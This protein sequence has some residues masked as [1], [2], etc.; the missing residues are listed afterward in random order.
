MRVQIKAT[1]IELTPAIEEYARKRL[2][3]LEKYFRSEDPD[4]VWA[5]VE[6]A[7]TTRHHKSGDVFKAEIFL[8]AN[9]K[10]YYAVSEEEDLYTA[11]DNVKDRLGH[12]VSSW[13]ERSKT[14]FRKGG[15]RVKNL[16]KRFNWKQ[17][18]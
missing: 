12:E 17:N 16:I 14:L 9:G 4:S 10:E 6:V 13:K 5:S 3:S 11:I 2:E 18:N 1:V 15:A 8:R 7:K